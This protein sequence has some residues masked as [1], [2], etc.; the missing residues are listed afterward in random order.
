MIVRR[1]AGE[2]RRLHLATTVRS[3]VGS[4]RPRAGYRVY[5]D[6]DGDALLLFVV[7]VATQ[8]HDVGWVIDY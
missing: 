4:R 8:T 5:F 3:C 7:G 2:G 6:Q 1:P